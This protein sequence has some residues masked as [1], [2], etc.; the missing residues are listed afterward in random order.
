[1]EPVPA[2]LMEVDEAETPPTYKVEPEPEAKTSPYEVEPDPPVLNPRGSVAEVST[3]LQFDPGSQKP[4]GSVADVPTAMDVD[5][6]APPKLDKRTDLQ[7][8]VAAHWEQQ[9]RDQEAI[10]EAIRTGQIT[11]VSALP[12]MY[13]D[14]RETTALRTT[15][16]HVSGSGGSTDLSAIADSRALSKN[17]IPTVT[18]GRCQWGFLLHG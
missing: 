16:A 11:A 2:G 10:D 9:A 3:A 17:K 14:H 7:K 18:V 5:V 15:A 4:R 12:S 6:S 8:R 13:Q 1:M